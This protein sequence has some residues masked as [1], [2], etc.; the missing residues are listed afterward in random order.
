MNSVYE[1]KE[2]CTG[3][4]LCKNICPTSAINMI[5]DSEGFYYPLIDSVKCIDCGLCKKNCPLI[6]PENKNETPSVYAAKHKDENIRATSTSGGAFTALS[7]VVLGYNG[8]VYGVMLNSNN[9]AVHARAD[10]KTSRNAFKGSKYVQSFF[11]ET[12]ELI[13]K[14][15]KK[16]RTVLFTGTPCQC[17]GVRRYVKYKGLN[18]NNIILCDIVCHGVHSP[19]LWGSHVDYLEKKKKSKI[20]EYYFRNKINGWHT[21]TEKAVFHNN[22]VDTKSFSSQ[23]NKKLYHT[24]VFFRPVCYECPYADIN[25]VSDITI[26][27][28]WGIEKYY[29]DFDDNKGVSLILI[30]SVKGAQ[31]F[32][33]AKDDLVFFPCNVEQCLQPQLKHPTARPKNRDKYWNIYNK[34][35]YHALAKKIR[36]NGYKR[37]VKTVVK[38]VLH[39]VGIKK[40][41]TGDK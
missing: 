28:F 26:A 18:F 10:N 11:G 30:N 4:T 36:L 41:K 20:R 32:E 34:G 19:K 31:I 23:L 16:N 7:D 39:S 37:K 38:K 29:P 15:L 2:K 9:V 3:C 21:H 6:N 14:D 40:L 12:L 27:D 24:N 13:E 25:R 33:E 5:A 22:L 17:D 35:G 1:L 8:V